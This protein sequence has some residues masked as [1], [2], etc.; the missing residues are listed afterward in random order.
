MKF[1]DQIPN[2]EA[3]SERNGLLRVCLI[4]GL[5]E[6]LSLAGT[7]SPD[8]RSGGQE[9]LA[10]AHGPAKV[11]DVYQAAQDADICRPRISPSLAPIRSG[12][13]QRKGHDHRPS[14]TQRPIGRMTTLA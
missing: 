10:V 5:S 1:A 4:P 2:N 13:V 9:P 14:S 12:R 7:F 11:C 3:A 8:Y 6:T